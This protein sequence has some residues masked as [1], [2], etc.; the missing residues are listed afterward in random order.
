MRQPGYFANLF[1][2][3]EIKRTFYEFELRK[4]IKV[5]DRQALLSIT[6]HKLVNRSNSSTENDLFD[7]QFHISETDFDCG[8]IIDT[9]DYDQGVLIVCQFTALLE[10]TLSE[11]FEPFS[12]GDSHCSESDC[13]HSA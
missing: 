2:F 3:D 10:E 1:L 11:C 4:K 7:I 6:Y 5:T 13:G 12:E 8:M 9:D